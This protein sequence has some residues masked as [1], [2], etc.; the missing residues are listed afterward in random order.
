MFGFMNKPQLQKLQKKVIK[1]ASEVFHTHQGGL[2]LG[3]LAFSLVY[4]S[5]FPSKHIHKVEH[6][7]SVGL[8]WVRCAF[9]NDGLCQI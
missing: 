6:I 4:C 1:F 3:A 2:L 7:I 8:E 5:G 9:G